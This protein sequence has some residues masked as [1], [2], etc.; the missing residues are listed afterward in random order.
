MDINT[1]IPKPPKTGNKYI[2]AILGLANNFV[3][4]QSELG[5]YNSAKAS[6]LT[7]TESAMTPS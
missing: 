7:L 1:F 6:V 4:G 5:L 2:D 3:P